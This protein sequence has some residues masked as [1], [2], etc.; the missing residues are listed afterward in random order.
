[1]CELANKGG[2]GKKTKLQARLFTSLP[3]SPSPSTSRWISIPQNSS[4]MTRKG[5]SLRPS[6]SVHVG[7]SS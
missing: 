2:L 3:T 5:L 1:M 7:Q 6:V 4:R